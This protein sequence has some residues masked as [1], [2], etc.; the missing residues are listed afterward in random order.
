ARRATSRGTG[1]TNRGSDLAPCLLGPGRSDRWIISDLRSR[2]G[3]REIV[4]YYHGKK[5]HEARL[6]DPQRRD[7]LAAMT[8]GYTPVMIEHLLDE[9]LVWALRRDADRLSWADLQRA[10]MTEEIGLGQPVEYTEA[11]R[12]TIATH[13]AGHATVAWL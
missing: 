9:A 12:R 7:T 8:S 4:D 3:R 11:E 6:D 13:E 5:A 2:A 10:K 1:G